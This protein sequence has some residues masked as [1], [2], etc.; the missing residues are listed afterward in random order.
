LSVVTAAEREIVEPSVR[1]FPLGP[2][3]ALGGLGCLLMAAPMALAHNN[4]G[5]QCP[6]KELTG[7]DC[8]GCGMTRAA[9]ALAHGNFIGAAD[10]NIFFVAMLPILAFG[11]FTW[12]RAS[13]QGKP[14]PL[15][16]AKFLYVTLA[17]AMVFTV[18][19]NIPGVPFLGSA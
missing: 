1:R 18:L 6:V 12:V 17:F 11:W 3:I 5:W 7:L 2:V 10:H 15:P 8:P 13:L 16:S 19:R 9:A 4:F 14:M